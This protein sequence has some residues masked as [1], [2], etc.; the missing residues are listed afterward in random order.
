MDVHGVVVINLARVNLKN[1]DAVSVAKATVWSVLCE[2]PPGA[3][4]RLVVPA[5]S[6]W[7]PFV[8]D[9]LLEHSEHLG[10]VT[11]ESDAKTVREWVLALRH[12]SRHL[13]AVSGK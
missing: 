2:T 12:G 9:L 13:K 11:V 3:D 4:V 7:C 8:A 1:R 6:W 5:W 10:S